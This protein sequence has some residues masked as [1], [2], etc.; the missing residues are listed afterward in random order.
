MEGVCLVLAQWPGQ[1]FSG[2]LVLIAVAVSLL[3]LI[4]GVVIVIWRQPQSTIP[5]HFKVPA[6][7]LLPVLS[8][9]VNVY[10]MMQMTAG[11]W[12]HFGIW[13]VIGFAI[14][15]GYGIWHSLDEKDDQQPTAT[16]S[17]SQA[18]Q[19]H[20]SSVELE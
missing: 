12:T 3:L 5:L 13:M 8:I 6:L 7:P 17:N 15:F 16:A 1:L 10:L 19:E 11:T 14:Y 18:L 2:D 9:F 4:V 20:T